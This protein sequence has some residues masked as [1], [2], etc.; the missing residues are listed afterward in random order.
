MKIPWNFEIQL[1][2]SIF[3]IQK[4]CNSVFFNK[5]G[6]ADDVVT[7]MSVSRISSDRT[8]FRIAKIL[9]DNHRLQIERKPKE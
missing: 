5:R 3:E 7:K 9:N 8:Y 6:F 1:K 2:F 4:T